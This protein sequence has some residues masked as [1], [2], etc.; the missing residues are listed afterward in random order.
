[1]Y[2]ANSCLYSSFHQGVAIPS[3]ILIANT[4]M[5]ANLEYGPLGAAFD[6]AIYSS[7]SVA[8]RAYAKVDGYA[9]LC[10]SSTPELSMFVPK[11]LFTMLGIKLYE[12]YGGIRVGRGAQRINLIKL[13]WKYRYSYRQSRTL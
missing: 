10:Y 4:R 1:M 6:E 3:S 11:A 7:P 8:L 12:I 2:T 5:P 13:K 9:I